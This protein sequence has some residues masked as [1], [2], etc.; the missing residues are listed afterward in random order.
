MPLLA[1]GD[2][3]GSLF[4]M[5]LI[6]FVVKA[7]MKKDAP[8]PTYPDYPPQPSALGWAGKKAAGYGVRYLLRNL[9]GRL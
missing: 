9:K 2:A 3:C 7:L 5:L 8:P 1:Q 6:F 4:V